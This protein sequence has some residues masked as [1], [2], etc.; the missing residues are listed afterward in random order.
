MTQR[1][2]ILTLTDAGRA[3]LINA[4]NN[5][6][7]VQFTAIALGSGTV[8]LDN[9]A[10]K[11]TSEQERQPIFSSSSPAPG[12]LSISALFSVDPAAQYTATELAL[13]GDGVVFGVW[14]TTDPA[15]A[16]VVRTPGVPYLSSITVG[17]AQLPSQN[18]SVIIQPLDAAVQALLSDTMTNTINIVFER[19][20]PLKDTGQ[21][22]AYAA[23]N[24]VPLT[25]ATLVHGTRQRVVIATTNNGASTYAPDGLPP[26]PVVGLDVSPLQGLELIATQTADLEYIVAP[27]VNAGNGAWLLIRCA[28]GALQ[29]APAVQSRHALQMAQVSGVVGAVRNLAMNIGV[30]SAQATMT[31][32]EIIVQTALGGLRY[33]VPV[34]NATINLAVTGAGGMDTGSAP[35]SGYVG[36]YAI[37]NPLAA[38]FMGSI[39]GNTL[40]VSSVGSGALAVGQYVQGAVPGTVITALGSGNGGTGTYTVSIAQNAATAQLSTAAVALLATNA[41]A[42]KVPEVY[43][44]ANMPAGYTASALVSVWPTNSSRQLI[45]ANQMDRTLCIPAVTVLSTSN[46]LSAVTALSVASAVPPNARSLSG[47]LGVFA[48]STTSTMALQLFT[49]ALSTQIGFQDCAGQFAASTGIYDSFRNLPMPTRQ[50]IYYLNSNSAGTP[51]YIIFVSGYDF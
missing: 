36:L 42:A 43:G 27:S 48:Q 24:V 21:V 10:T 29:V 46:V 14:S 8:A 19:L 35:A 31:A 4:A 20:A 33:C 16:L 34:F 25:A 7:D 12:Q 30:A 23:V 32:D 22:N 9:T 49:Q 17:Y 26:K 44:G 15:Q 41:T 37:F 13:I 51:Q 50:S 39:A 3:A 38:L 40:T 28:A 18:V 11:L 45:T 47:I 2:I 6:A 5:S 1:N